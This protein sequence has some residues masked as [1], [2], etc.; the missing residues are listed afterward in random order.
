LRDWRTEG[1]EN[2]NIFQPFDV[3]G[4]WDIPTIQPIYELPDLDW[5][6][7][8]FALTHKNIEG[9]GLHFFLDDYQI[10]RIWKQP[11]RYIDMLLKCSAALAPDFSMY[12]DMPKALQIYNHYRRHWCAQYWQWLG[13]KVIPTIGWS[14]PDSWEWCFDGEPTGSIV[15]ISTVGTQKNKY[16]MELFVSGFQEMCYRLKPTT[17]ICHGKKLDFMNEQGVNIVEIQPF[18]NRFAKMRK[19][20]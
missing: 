10:N 17:I 13:I 20:K 5:I 8:N 2:F 11:Q 3:A 19:E 9:K 4:K 14:T 12:I 15:A 16:S 18:T 1:L 6:G 7:F